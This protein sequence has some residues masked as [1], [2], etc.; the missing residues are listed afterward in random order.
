[1]LGR[2]VAVLDNFEQQLQS[3]EGKQ[4]AWAVLRQL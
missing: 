3:P 1:V 4:A 2:N